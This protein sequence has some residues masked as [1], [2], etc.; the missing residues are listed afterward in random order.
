MVVSS[1]AAAAAAIV[2]C[3]FSGA[4]VMVQDGFVPGAGD[5]EIALCEL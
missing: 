5:V 3:C 1:E 4:S 2:A